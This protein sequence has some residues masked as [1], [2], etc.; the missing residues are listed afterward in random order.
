MDD[1]GEITVHGEKKKYCDLKRVFIEKVVNENTSLT[2]PLKQEGFYQGKGKMKATQDFLAPPTQ[3]L[4]HQK[5]PVTFHE[6]RYTPPEK[7]LLMTTLSGIVQKW[8]KKKIVQYELKPDL[9]GPD[10]EC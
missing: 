1:K 5:R 4:I 3:P 2:C 8:H 6:S 10:D 9:F 7:T